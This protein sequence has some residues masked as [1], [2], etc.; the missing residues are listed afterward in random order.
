MERDKRRV[1]PCDFQRVEEVDL[2]VSGAPGHRRVPSRGVQQ[3]A[4]V[5]KDAAGGPGPSTSKVDFLKSSLLSVR[6]VHDL[7]GTQK[8]ILNEFQ[9][10]D[11]SAKLSRA[12]LNIEYL[13]H[14]SELEKEV[15][16]TSLKNFF[17]ITENARRLVESCCNANWCQAAALQINNE[18]A[19]REI[20]VDTGLCYD[21]IYKEVGE[22]SSFEIEDLRQSSAF[23]PATATE[24]R[25]DQ[26]KL[27]KRLKELVLTETTR[28]TEGL[29]QR[30]RL[31][32]HLLERLHGML[33]NENGGP[34]SDLGIEWD[35]VLLDPWGETCHSIRSSGVLRTTWLGMPCAK[36]VF[37]LGECNR[38]QFQTEATILSMLNHPNLVKFFHC[39]ND[40]SECCIA[41]ELMEGNL[42][43]LIQEQV[44]VGRKAPFPLPVAV[45][46]MIQ[47]ANGMCYLHDH[48]VAHRHLK[49]ANVLVIRH[50]SP[51]LRDY[52]HVKLADFGLLKTDVRTSASTI[53]TTIYGAPEVFSQDGRK[54]K[55]AMKSDVYSFAVLASYIL[56]G[57]KPFEGIPASRLSDAILN[58][59]VRPKLPSH[60]PEEL[61]SIIRDCWVRDFRKRPLFVD[62]CCRLESV[63]NG[64]S[65]RDS[66]MFQHKM[67]PAFSAYAHG[68][69]SERSAVRQRNAVARDDT[70]RSL[71]LVV[72]LQSTSVMM[73]NSTFQFM[74]RLRGRRL[75]GKEEFCEMHLLL[76]DQRTKPVVLRTYAL[77]TMSI[78][79][80]IVMLVFIPELG[81]T[82]IEVDANKEWG[83]C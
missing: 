4:E 37:K 19:F 10:W 81:Y 76:I 41:M 2:E 12:A 1:P 66:Y 63:R 58:N 11:L 21:E 59:N 32:L 51:Y 62:I 40:N 54:A 3:V 24:I 67:G 82:L 34:R 22:T 80:P 15:F 50:N 29:I 68:I 35:N 48:Q 56:T 65:R 53:R 18:E 31:A 44:E 8:Q 73:R 79:V 60:C 39:D 45:D 78:N 7:L 64:L 17:R 70:V 33:E 38:A 5:E 55:I 52:L 42:Q 16:D 74:T 23:S 71:D 26:E 69:C 25:K 43:D 83:C 57:K 49:P 13:V 20:L 61:A 30:R 9:C 46:I 77:E 28:W 27:Y 72:Q 75:T 14:F 36:K 47:I 6:R